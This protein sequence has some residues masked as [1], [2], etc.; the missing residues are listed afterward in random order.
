MKTFCTAIFVSLAF[1]A[2]PAC[3]QT[4]ALE[5][6][7]P[8]EY[9]TEGG[10][11]VLTISHQSD[12]TTGFSIEVRGANAHQCNLAGTIQGDRAIVETEQPGPPCVIRFERHTSSLVVADNGEE[13]CRSFCGMRAHFEGEYQM[14]T[15]GCTREEGR[16]ACA[17]FKRLYASQ[18]YDEAAE[19]LGS[20]QTRCAKTL[21]VGPDCTLNDL[22]IA[23]YHLGRL[24]DC[25]KT[26]EPLAENAAKT[27]E[28]LK[29]L[30]PPFDLI[31]ALPLLRAARHN[32]KLC[33]EKER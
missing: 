10:S 23:Q 2:F 20:R 11:G 6:P 16:A 18:S 22:A 24:A 15:P 8:G 26:L 5:E 3:G 17:Q 13:A 25:R 33:A 1:A 28:E 19:L 21:G 27:D 9:L 32:L 30:Y 4:A 14:P 12:Q 29:R 7:A 31:E